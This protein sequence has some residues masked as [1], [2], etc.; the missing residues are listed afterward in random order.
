M[1]LYLL[2]TTYD[3]E[4][5]EAQALVKLKTGQACIA[6]AGAIYRKDDDERPNET[7]YQVNKY[8]TCI[9]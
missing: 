2:V 9:F 6:Q 4:K 8:L 7:S 3:T 1:F 5:C